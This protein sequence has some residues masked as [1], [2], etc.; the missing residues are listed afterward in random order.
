MNIFSY[1]LQEKIQI[2]NLWINIEKNTQK[3]LVV[4]A[5]LNKYYGLT[6]CSQNRESSYG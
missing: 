2:L 5:I 6:E 4:I 3:K 1:T